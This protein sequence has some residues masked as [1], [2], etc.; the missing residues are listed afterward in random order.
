MSADHRGLTLLLI[1]LVALVVVG[2][3][4]VGTMMGPGVMM[5]PGM[6]WGPSTQGAAPN[7][8]GWTWGL[9][10]TFGWLAMRAFWGVLSVGWV[11]GVRW[12]AGPQPHATQPAADSP[13]DILKRRYAAGEIDQATYTRMRQEIQ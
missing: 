13:G 11:L 12:A 9:G 10:M 1:I 7:M 4:M 6:M 2:P 3:L 5:G 8:P